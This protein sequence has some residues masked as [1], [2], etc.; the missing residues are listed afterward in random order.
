MVMQIQHRRGTSAEHAVFTGAEGEITVN[1]DNDSLVVHDGA[2]PGGHETAKLVDLASKADQASLDTTDATLTSAVSGLNAADAALTTSIG[3]KADQ[4]ALDAV[5]TTL[6][7]K[8]DQSALDAVV[9]ATDLNTS[10]IAAIDLSG[11]AAQDDLDT[12]EAVVIEGLGNLATDIAANANAAANISINYDFLLNHD[13][14]LEGSAPL[15]GES[16]PEIMIDLATGFGTYD[17][18]I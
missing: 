15:P 10:A 6:A 2:T 18:N 4:T 17:L 9:A 12:L 16:D 3:L 5:S 7:G 11:L 13:L 14:D 1:I 8:A